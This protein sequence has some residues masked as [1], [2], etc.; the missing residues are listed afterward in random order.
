M[1]AVGNHPAETTG[2]AGALVALLVAILKID[3]PQVY[4][5]LIV[6]VGFVPAAV[7]WLV[8]LVRGRKVA[9]E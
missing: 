6:L 7:T 2:A 9:G 1:N 5:A 8:L 4:Q 3:D